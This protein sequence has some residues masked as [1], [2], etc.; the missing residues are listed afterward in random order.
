MRAGLFRRLSNSI[1]GLNASNREFE[2]RPTGI[3]SM[4]R[5]FNNSIEFRNQNEWTRSGIHFALSIQDLY[6]SVKTIL[7]TNMSNCSKYYPLMIVLTKNFLQ[8]NQQNKLAPHMMQ[9]EEIKSHIILFCFKFRV[10]V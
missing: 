2:F 6:F 3:W 8:M 10:L 4:R 5:I 9:I 7:S 1:S